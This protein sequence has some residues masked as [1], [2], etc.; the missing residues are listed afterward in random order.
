MARIVRGTGVVFPQIKQI[1]SLLQDYPK[2]IRRKYMKA[3]FNAAA[4]VGEKKLKQITPRGPT[5]NLKKSVK[6]KASPGY[7]LAGYEAGRGGKGYHQGFLEFGTKERFTDGRYA[8]TFRSKTA[9]RGGAMRIVVGSRGSNAGK[10]VT[11]SPNYPKS[12]FKSAPSGKRVSL[13]KMPIGGRL[14]K[15]PVRAAFEQSRGQITSVL[16]QQMATVLER[17]N[18][19]MARQAAGTKS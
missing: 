7:G 12:F 10:L 11:K 4:K 9:G 16:Q 13:K 19:D 17:A 18:K 15:P 6:K 1:R 14:G 8:S 2:S 3:A 5:G